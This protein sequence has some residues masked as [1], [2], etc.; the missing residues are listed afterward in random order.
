MM[1]KTKVFFIEQFCKAK[2]ADVYAFFHRAVF[3]E[4]NSGSNKWH[5]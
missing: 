2:L 5:N 3:S 4:K 1:K